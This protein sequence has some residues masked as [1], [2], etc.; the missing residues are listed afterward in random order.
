[1][2]DPKSAKKK[3]NKCMHREM[4]QFLMLIYGSSRASV[5][6]PPLNFVSSFDNAAQNVL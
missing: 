1:M 5:P 3:V 4:V 6:P 2:S